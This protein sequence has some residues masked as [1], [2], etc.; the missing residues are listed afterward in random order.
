MP[1][2]IWPQPLTSL[3]ADWT[4]LI[5][6]TEPRSVVLLGDFGSLLLVQCDYLEWICSTVYCYLILTCSTFVTYSNSCSML[7]A[8]LHL[9][10]S[11]FITEPQIC[12]LIQS[13]RNKWQCEQKTD[14]DYCV[15]SRTAS[16]LRQRIAEWVR[17]R[18]APYPDHLTADGSSQLPPV[19][20]AKQRLGH[21][22]PRVS[23]HGLLCVSRRRSRVIHFEWTRTQLLP[24]VC[25]LM[26]QW[27]DCRRRGTDAFLLCGPAVRKSALRGSASHSASAPEI[28]PNP[29]GA[30]RS[31]PEPHRAR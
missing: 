12:S 31:P 21:N 28:C 29:G 7:P 6:V 5:L 4:H 26:N 17:V 3:L 27:W 23:A 11:L 13:Q 15:K 22:S 16:V 30:R 24:G 1:C 20:H 19:C 25:F 8:D 14:E 18:R 2:L 9:N 10:E